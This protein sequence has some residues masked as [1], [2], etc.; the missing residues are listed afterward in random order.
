M[1][2]E[3]TIKEKI[4]QSATAAQVISII[5]LVLMI[6]TAGSNIFMALCSEYTDDFAG[7]IKTAAEGIIMIFIAYNCAAIFSRIVESGTPFNFSNVK[8][9]RIIALCI[10]AKNIVSGFA[11]GLAVSIRSGEFNFDAF[12]FDTTSTLIIGALVMVLAQIFSYGTMLQQES[13]ETV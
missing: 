7:Y 4:E 2:K 8:S 10:M 11:Y 12:S 1:Q 3:K 13:D 6:I 5:T 9:L